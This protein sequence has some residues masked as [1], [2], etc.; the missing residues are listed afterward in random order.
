M[1]N[2]LDILVG[3]DIAAAAGDIA[4]ATGDL[5]AATGDLVSKDN[6]G[7]GTGSSPYLVGELDIS[8]D[9]APA[10]E[11]PYLVGELDTADTTRGPLRGVVVGGTLTD[12]GALGVNARLL[13]DGEILLVGALEMDAP[14]EGSS[15]KDNLDARVLVEIVLVLGETPVPTVLVGVV[16]MDTV[17][18]DL[19]SGSVDLEK[20]PLDWGVDG[21][22]GVILIDFLWTLS[23]SSH[24]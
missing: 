7:A 23:I 10:E 15:P 24:S 11:P 12:V 17:L 2:D 13:I 14:I 21:I 8:R 18:R 16:E 19:D 1:L 6:L 20:T 4:A 9:C 5:A 22:L 3:E